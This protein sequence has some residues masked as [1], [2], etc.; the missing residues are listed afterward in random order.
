MGNFSF[1][2]RK[3]SSKLV[4]SVQLILY[5]IQVVNTFFYTSLSAQFHGTITK[6]KNYV[7]VLAEFHEDKTPLPSYETLSFSFLT[8]SAKLMM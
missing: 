8:I 3:L 7:I 1:D 4:V 5:C 6:T 2:K